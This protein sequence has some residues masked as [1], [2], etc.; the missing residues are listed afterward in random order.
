MA[1][2]VQKSVVIRVNGTAGASIRSLAKGCAWPE[3]RIASLLVML[4]NACLEGRH[5]SPMGHELVRA[6]I[7]RQAEVKIM[8]EAQAR[9]KALRQ[10]E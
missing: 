6:L 8:D 3:S 7:R 9:I 5:E 2:K 1:K 10:A 4:G